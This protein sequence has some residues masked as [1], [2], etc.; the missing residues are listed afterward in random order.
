MPEI[1]IEN[2]TVTYTDKKKNK[3]TALND[4]SCSFE[5]GK[6]NVIVGPSGCGKTTLLNAICKNI[7]YQGNIFFDNKNSYDLDFKDVAIGY[8]NQQFVLYPHMTVFENI[9]FPLFAQKVATEEIRYMVRKISNE[10]QLLPCLNRKPN[11]ISI[12]QQQRVALARALVKS[13]SIC[14]FDEALSNLDKPLANELMI[15]LKRL[16][17]E[18][19]TTVVYSTHSFDEAFFLGDKIFVINEGKLEAQGSPN[20]LIR[21]NN[22]TIK[23]LIE[24]TK[25][26]L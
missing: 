16:F 24:S 3:I 4:F 26:K 25:F 8:V 9:A 20:E 11:E 19:K 10:L 5:N 22:E 18:N 12:G 14:L 2:L 6:I 7:D 17:V 1:K 21:S 13:P 15:L 23:Y